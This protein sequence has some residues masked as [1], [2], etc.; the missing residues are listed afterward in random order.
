MT[1]SAEDRVKN[2]SKPAEAN[3]VEEVSN[4]VKETQQTYDCVMQHMGRTIYEVLE[5]REA[6]Q[7]RQNEPEQQSEATEQ[8]HHSRSHRG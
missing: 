5:Q 4:L 3:L 1:A 6:K 2:P 8:L 7:R